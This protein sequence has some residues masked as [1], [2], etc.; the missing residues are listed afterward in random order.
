M[1]NVAFCLASVELVDLP[2]EILL[3]IMRKVKPL[4]ELLTSLIDVGKT[5]LENFV[6]DRS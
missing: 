2:D 6:L 1:S 5:R 3:M 4:V